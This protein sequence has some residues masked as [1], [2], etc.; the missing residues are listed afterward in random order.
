MFLNY[1]KIAWRSLK[2]N[3][4]YTIINVLGLAIGLT[5]FILILL[6][7]KDELAYDRYHTKVDRIYRLCEKIDMEGQGENSSSNPFPTGPAV[8]NDYPHLVEKQTRFFN[9][10]QDKMSF[11]IAEGNEGEDRKFKEEDI[12]FADST[13]FDVFDFPLA[14]GNPAEALNGPNKM[15]LTQELADKFFPGEDPIGKT[16]LYD[17]GLPIEITGILGDVPTQSHFT[18]RGLISFATLRPMMGRGLTNNWVWNP[19]WTY[20]LLKEGVTPKELEDQ[21]PIFVQKY[22][23]DFMKDQIIHYLQPLGDI[24]LT[25]TLDYEIEP[26]SKKSNIYIFTIIGIFILLIAC[27][28]FM[29]LATAR[30]SRRAQEVGIRKVLGAKRSQLVFQFLGESLMITAFAG[31]MSIVFVNLLMPIFNQL[32]AKSLRMSDL[33]V[34][35][36]LLMMLG[37][38]VLVGIIAGLYPAFYLSSFLP[39][40]VL[41]G[42]LAADKFNRIFRKSLVVLQFAISLGLIIGTGVIYSQYTYMRS[43]DPGFQKDHVMI[44]PAARPTVPKYELFKEDLKRDAHIFEVSKMNEVIGVHHNVHEYNFEG[45]KPGEWMYFPSLI[46]DEDF[47]ETMGLEIIAGRDFGLETPTDDTLGVLINETMVKERG[48]ATPVEALNQQFYTPRGRERVIGVVKDF[49]AVSLLDPIRPFVLDMIK[50]GVG[51]FFA[52]NYV[53]RLKPANLEQTL[54]HCEK[55]WNKVAPNHPFEYYFLNE[56]IDELYA[57]Q[58]RLAKLIAYF[59]ILAILIAC[60]GLFALASFSTEQRTKEI[61][62]RKVMGAS[63]VQI[64]GMLAWDFIKLVLF[65]SLIAFGLAGYF[66]NDWLSGFA[67]RMDMPWWIYLAATVLVGLLALLTVGFHSYK[68]GSIN[69]A[70]ALKSE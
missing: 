70:N 35:E 66:L 7:V 43:A 38:T 31:V 37:I 63:I 54:A 21:F 28:N 64:F 53:V 25:S 67:F 59:S 29:N 3:R 33:L 17:G 51:S 23:P 1:L 62:I 9:F 16:V 13:T 18:F 50:T 14:K 6:F 36:F 46:V 55:A 34:P 44:I 27:V 52:K 58:S 11:R 60:S 19:N 69:P 5:S 48:W 57:D 10:Q 26:N 2:R 65:G 15:I 24:H 20:L 47:V 32:S 42:K 22:Y 30:S 39:V 8:V 4:F 68:A 49:H 56:Q 61:G 40:K 41:K 45:M 12:F